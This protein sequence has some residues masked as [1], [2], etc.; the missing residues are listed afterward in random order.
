MNVRG[1][2]GGAYAPGCAAFERQLRIITFDD[3]SQLVM[4]A[5]FT[6]DS[7]QDRY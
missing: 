6:G 4:Y 7:P 3:G 1:E 5:P 2:R